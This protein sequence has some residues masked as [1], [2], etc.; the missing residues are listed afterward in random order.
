MLESWPVYNSEMIESVRRVLAAGEVNYL[1]GKLGSKFENDFSE[2][3]GAKHSICLANGSLALSLAYRSLNLKPGDE[4]ITSPRSFIAT[5]SEASLLGLKVIFADLDRNSG[6]ISADTIQPLIT[7]KTKAISV[8]HIGGWPADMNEI[9]SLAKKYNLQVIEDCAQ[10]HGAKINDKSV[11]TFGD[12]GAW[13]FCQDKIISTG[14]EGG[15]ITTNSQKKYEYMWSFKDHGKSIEKLKNRSVKPGYKFLHDQLGTNYRLT[16][17]QSAIGIIQLEMLEDWR[18]K[19]ASNANCFLTA[20]KDIP[21]IRMPIPKEGYQHA[22]YKFY[23]YLDK[24]LLNKQW[25]RDKIINRINEHGY[26]AFHGGCGEIYKE[27][28]FNQ[29]DFYANKM[30]VAKEL[31]ESSLM[32]LVH[33]TIRS[34]QMNLYALT[35][36]KVLEEAS[37]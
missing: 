24:R 10:A 20:L 22:W 15:M 14:G 29:S 17:M 19:R 25:D 37:L 28:S 13:S 5:A 26:P 30:P 4:I 27:N 34:E 11:G 2:Y 8:V 35:V 9:C 23:C 33:P 1:F 6:C 21:L 12:V 7:E 36:K 3:T 31:F 16:E 32:L 18:S